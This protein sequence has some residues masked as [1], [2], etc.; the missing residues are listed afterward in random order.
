MSLIKNLSSL[1]HFLSNLPSF[2][3]YFNYLGDGIHTAGGRSGNDNHYVEQ[4]ERGNKALGMFQKKV[5]FPLS[6]EMW[7]LWIFLEWCDDEKKWWKFSKNQRL[8]LF[9]KFLGKFHFFGK[10]FG[11]GFLLFAFIVMKDFLEF[12]K[13]NSSLG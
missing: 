1:S 7:R 11:I 3:R 5:N 6:G 10:N 12:N 4:H 8:N 13:K 2:V 9:W